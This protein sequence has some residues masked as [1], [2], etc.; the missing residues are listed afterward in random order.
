MIVRTAILFSVGLVLA[1]GMAVWQYSLAPQGLL[2]YTPA[3][4]ETMPNYTPSSLVGFFLCA[5]ALSV[6]SAF[7][8]LA[9]YIASVAFERRSLGM[10]KPALLLTMGFGLLCVFSTVSEKYWP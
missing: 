8:A 3:A 4:G 2:L 10:V 1:I 6:L 9:G 5:F 7:V